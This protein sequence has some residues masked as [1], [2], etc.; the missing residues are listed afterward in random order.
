M[1][2]KGVLRE[3]DE[4]VSGQNNESSTGPVLRDRLR[5]EVEQCD[6]DH[7][8]RRERDQLVER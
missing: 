3:V 1:R 7:E 8:A 2:R 6:R 5:N 4:D